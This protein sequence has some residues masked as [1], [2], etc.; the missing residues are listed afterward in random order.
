MKHAC[1]SLIS[2]DYEVKKI[3]FSIGQ[4]E[5][6][7]DIWEFA[8]YLIVSTPEQL[9]DFPRLAHPNTYKNT[10]PIFP[11]AVILDHQCPLSPHIC[12]HAGWHRV[13][14]YKAYSSS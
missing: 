4:T 5:K 10:L 6:K 1:H 12:I 11:R 3:E 2:N 7:I 9:D 13:I 8:I 14:G